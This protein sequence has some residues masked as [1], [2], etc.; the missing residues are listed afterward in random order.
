VRIAPTRFLVRAAPDPQYQFL[1]PP[2][3]EVQLYLDLEGNLWLSIPAR[4]QRSRGTELAT[5]QAGRCRFESH[6]PLSFLT[7]MIVGL[8]SIAAAWESC[9]VLLRCDRGAQSA[10]GRACLIPCSLQYGRDRSGIVPNRP[11]TGLTLCAAE[12]RRFGASAG[13]KTW[14]RANI[15]V[16]KVSSRHPP[17]ISLLWDDAIEANGF[18][19]RTPGFLTV[20]GEIGIRI[21]C[22]TNPFEVRGRMTGGR[23]ATAVC[24]PKFG[25]R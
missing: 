20:C 3:A 17:C 8:G 14:K 10:Y 21:A 16:P 19:V 22:R 7:K 15:T 12:R 25:T 13:G 23:L 18:R 1:E 4:S 11:S 2:V 9:R 6:R 24:F 5:S